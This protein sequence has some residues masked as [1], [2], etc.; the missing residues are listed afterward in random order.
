MPESHREGTK[1]NLKLWE[2]SGEILDSTYNVDLWR[3]ILHHQAQNQH[4]RCRAAAP[5]SPRGGNGFTLARFLLIGPIIAIICVPRRNHGGG[6]TFGSTLAISVLV[7]IYFRNGNTK[8]TAVQNVLGYVT[9]CRL[10]RFQ[11]ILFQ[12]AQGEDVI[13]DDGVYW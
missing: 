3:Q 10:G 12:D 7:I 1:C 13:G 2:G 6:W 9:I 5:R 8:L 11:A 4:Y